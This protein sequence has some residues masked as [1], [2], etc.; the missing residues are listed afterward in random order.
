M[1]MRLNPAELK[2]FSRDILTGAGMTSAP[3]ESVSV[4]LLEAQLL[5]HVTH[6]LALLPDYVE[7]L[8]SGS[9]TP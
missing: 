6:G 4:G 5:G 2:R 1:V 3:A 9:M 8:L 7:E